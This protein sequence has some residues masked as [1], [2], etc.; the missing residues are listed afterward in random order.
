MYSRTVHLPVIGKQ[1]VV[2][3][4]YR[5]DPHVLP[6]RGLSLTPRD[7][8]HVIETQA[9]SIVTETRARLQL[10]GRLELDEPVEYDISET[11]Q[12]SF[13]L[14]DS[15]KRLLRRFRT[16]LDAA[17]YDSDADT[18]QVTVWPPLPLAVRINLHRVRD[19][20]HNVRWRI[21]ALARAWRRDTAL[22]AQ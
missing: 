16:S 8:R 19:G 17:A 18:A 12:L 3:H 2:R 5:T 21:N 10:R 14:T 22:T 1:T 13:S 11:G 4:Q 6:F 7:V 9:L 15:T 20:S